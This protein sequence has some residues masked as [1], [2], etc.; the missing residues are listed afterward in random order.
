MSNT[1]EEISNIDNKRKRKK[2]KPSSGN[3]S[4]NWKDFDKLL[5]MQCTLREVASFFECS[6]DTIEN[7]VKKEKLCTFSEYSREKKANGKRQLRKRQMDIAMQGNTTMLIWLGKQYLDQKDKNE[8]EH[9]GNINIS[10][11]KD[12]LDV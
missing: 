1:H 9:S 8:I 5:S 12:E 7:I 10:I 4:V 6:E 11:F 3:I 2:Q